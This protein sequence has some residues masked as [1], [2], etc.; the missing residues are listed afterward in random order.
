MTRMPQFILDL[1]NKQN[2]FVWSNNLHHKFTDVLL[3][4]NRLFEAVSRIGYKAAVGV[5]VALTELIQEMVKDR[6][7]YI[8]A[9]REFA[10]K[11]E[12][13]WA[14]AIDPFYLKDFDFEYKYYDENRDSTPYGTNWAVLYFVAKEYTE[15]SFY[16]HQYLVNLS[17]L[18]RHLI[19]DK[20][21]FDNWFAETIR[22]TVE[23]F[24]CPY[25]YDDLDMYD[26]EA[27][28]DCSDDAPV[29]RE[30]FF[31]SEFEYSEEAAKPVLNAFL[32]SLDY[33]NNPWLC[34]PEEI[35]AKGFKGEPY[36]VA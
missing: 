27:K 10:P 25:D 9:A 8:D 36:K 6:Y 33:E 15:G 24:P 2:E 18:A 19:S 14:G 29:P 7:P 30:F 5:A 26:D 35:L 31:D 22:R 3:T 34:T 4:N 17:M 32:R 12:A 28:Y 1:K 13:L 21:S 23:A 20:K 11:I 16:I